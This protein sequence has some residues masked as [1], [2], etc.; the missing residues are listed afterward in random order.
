LNISR[1][2]GDKTSYAATLFLY[3]LACHYRRRRAILIQDNA[4]YHKDAEVSF[5]KTRYWGL[6]P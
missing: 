2:I 5:A 1:R 3:E 4:S 6:A